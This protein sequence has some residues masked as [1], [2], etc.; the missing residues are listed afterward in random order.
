MSYTNVKDMRSAAAALAL[1]CAAQFMVILDVTV[2]NVALP[3]I[4]ADLGV[5][6]GDLQWVVT[7]YT[8]VFG[9]LLMLGGRAGDVLG[10]RRVFVAGL[11]LFTASSLAAGLAPSEPLLLA[12]RALQGAGA[13]LLSPSTLALLTAVFPE[14]PERHRALATWGALGAAGAGAGVLLGGVL[15]E[16]AGWRSAFLV[17]VP[18]GVAG[19]ALAGR[20]LPAARPSGP[21]PAL[22]L[23]GAPLLTG[24]LVALIYGLSRADDAGWTAAPTVLPAAAGLALV[25]AFAARQSA[26]PHPL[27]PLRV[28]RRRAASTALGLMLLA[29]GTMVATFFLGSLHLQ[30]QLGHSALRTGLEFL[31]VALTVLAAAHAGG[32]VLARAGIRTLLAAGFA[33]AAAGALLLADVGP[34]AS[35][36]ADVL[37]GLAV[38]AA[39]LGLAFA[40]ITVTVMSGA[41]HDDAGILS[42]LTTTAHEL[43]AS[44]VVAVLATVAAAGGTGDAF[45]VAAGVAAAG[46]VVALAGLRAGDV[47]AP[48]GRPAFAHH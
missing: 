43:G 22:D 19:V 48:E 45:A 42:G 30:Q 2:V 47:R 39:G 1:L 29:A 27:V 28:F 41:G 33:L 31:P 40:G 8:L 3:S 7:A 46:A 14:G 21:R 32:H 24:G 37:P 25:A 11:A 44:V 15:T 38:M 18:V 35:Y 34:G 36:A 10:R 16:L 5:A 26:V 13:A 9:G 17:N 4:Q 23:L 12:A 6:S 20:T